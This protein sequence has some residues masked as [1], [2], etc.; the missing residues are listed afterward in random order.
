MQN[1]SNVLCIK[2]RTIA[3]TAGTFGKDL[4]AKLTSK[5]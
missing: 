1:T 2:C 5:K 4:E 3:K